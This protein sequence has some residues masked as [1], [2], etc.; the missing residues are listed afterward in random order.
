MTG[1]TVGKVSADYRKKRVRRIKRIIILLVLLLLIVPSVLCIWLLF[2]VNDLET[3]VDQ[4]RLLDLAV[5]TGPAAT[6]TPQPKVEVVT[7]PAVATGP[8][9]VT[10]KPGKGKKVYLT[11]D[12]GPGPNTERIL[13]ILKKNDVKATFL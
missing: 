3:Q 1:D 2:R 5:A 6:S 11:F 13:D 9:A 7:G 4:L 12:D 8:A 10:E